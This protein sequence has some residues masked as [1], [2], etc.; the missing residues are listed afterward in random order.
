MKIKLIVDGGAM[1]PGPAVAQQLGPA[2]I[3]IGKVIADVN[4]ATAGFKGTKVPVEID[5]DTKVKTYSIA[6]FSP[7][8][9]ELLKKELGLEKGSGEAK[10]TKVGNIALERIISVAKTKMPNLLAKDLKSAV[11]LIVGSCVSLGILVDNKPAKEIEKDIDAGKYDKEIKQEITEVSADKK[12]LL[13]TFFKEVVARQEKEKK[14]AEEAAAAAEAAKAAAL[15]AAGG[16]VPGAA[17]IA[18]AAPAAAAG[19][20]GAAAPAAASAAAGKAAAPVAG[21]AAAPAKAEAKKK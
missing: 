20:K 4:T 7:P 1:K 14:A 18:G 3:N 9:A 6:V 2:G 5:V 21:K 8:V 10:K 19:I 17:P 16:A 13:E 12:K 11:K 15:A